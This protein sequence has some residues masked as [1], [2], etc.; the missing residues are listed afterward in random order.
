MGPPIRPDEPWSDNDVREDDYI[1]LRDYGVIY[2]KR[3]LQ[4]R[5]KDF[6]E[7]FLQLKPSCA[8]TL[9]FLHLIETTWTSSA[10]G[11]D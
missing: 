6:Q 4:L 8:M 7:P 9:K 3:N 5:T 2:A 1:Y 10:Q 11:G